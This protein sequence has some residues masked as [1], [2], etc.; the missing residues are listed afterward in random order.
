M[1]AVSPYLHLPFYYHINNTCFFKKELGKKVNPI[2]L[3]ER[4]IIAR[5]FPRKERWLV[6][7]SVFNVYQFNS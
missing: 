5:K 1:Y 3:N 7:F 2:S 6:D 4:I